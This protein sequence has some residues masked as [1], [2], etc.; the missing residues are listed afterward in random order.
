MQEGGPKGRGKRDRAYVLF[1]GFSGRRV[2]CGKPSH[3]QQ[4]RSTSDA[5][6]SGPTS[7]AAPSPQTPR[8]L[9]EYVLAS[10]PSERCVVIFK[11]KRIGDALV[12]VCM[13]NQKD[14]D[15]SVP[16]ACWHLLRGCAWMVDGYLTT[17]WSRCVMGHFPLAACAL[18]YF[19]HGKPTFASSHA[20][21]QFTTTCP[22]IIAA[23]GRG[24][25]VAMAGW[26]EK[27]SG[28]RWSFGRALEGALG[29]RRTAGHSLGGDEGVWCPPLTGL[30]VVYGILR[31]TRLRQE[32]GVLSG[33]CLPRESP[34]DQD[35]FPSRPPCLPAPP[36]TPPD[37][38]R[39]D[40]RAW[41][42]Q[43]LS[44]PPPGKKNPQNP[45]S[46]T[47]DDVNPE[48]RQSLRLFD[49]PRPS[50]CHGHRDRVRQS[51]TGPSVFRAARPSPRVPCPTAQWIST[52]PNV[53][54][55][56]HPCDKPRPSLESSSNN[57]DLFIYYL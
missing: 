53:P 41:K 52:T 26:L 37:S 7:A 28:R 22:P 13:G 42:L 1:G 38:G 57:G 36:T 25:G 21:T 29:R 24:C 23:S 50:S 16:L 31:L 20:H 39:F 10:P 12:S 56:M 4:R 5:E 46:K 15:G 43:P 14:I 11:R 8:Y 17:P 27:V 35:S 32:I 3:R 51:I 40:G 54:V 2:I 33:E 19:R 18:P 9:L 47:W 6:F 48:F 30:D 55:E 45:L 49:R 34:N 44:P